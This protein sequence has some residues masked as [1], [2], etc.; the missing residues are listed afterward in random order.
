[1]VSQEEKQREGPIPKPP[2]SVIFS[3]FLN[4]QRYNLNNFK[5]NR[6]TYSQ[7]ESYERRNYNQGE[8]SKRRSSFRKSVI[9]GNCGK[10]GHIK[11]QCYKI[12]GYPIGHPL[13]GKYQPPKQQ[14]QEY[15]SNRTI[16]M[17]ATQEDPST[18]AKQHKLHS[19][20][21][22]QMS[23]SQLGLTCSKI[24]SIKYSS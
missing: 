21:L 6:P 18:Q 5:G 22:F 8:K 3:T 12:V 9:C 1:M 14:R 4:N 2:T 10:E 24:N 15:K 20:T 19:Q 11:E 17:A 7:G 16:N 13:H 23:I